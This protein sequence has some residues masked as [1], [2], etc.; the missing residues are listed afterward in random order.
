MAH[1]FACRKWLKWHEVG[2]LLWVFND[3]CSH[4]ENKHRLQGARSLLRTILGI[5]R[6]A[7]AGLKITRSDRNW[8]I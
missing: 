1:L 5:A 6:T 4:K 7:L 8:G 2:A 3:N